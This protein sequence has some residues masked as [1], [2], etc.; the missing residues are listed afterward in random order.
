VV[1]N[2]S[3]SVT[4]SGAVLTVL[5]LPVI[6]TQPLSSATFAGGSVTLAGA[7]SGNPAPGYQWQK[8]GIDVVGATSGTLTLNNVQLSD[9]G[10]YALVATNSVGVATSR[11]ARLVVLVPRANAAVYNVKAY[12][13]GA[14]VGGN[15]SVEYG[16]TNVGTQN[17]GANHFLAVRDSQGLFVAFAPLLGTAAGEDRI[18]NVNFPAPA[19][20]GTYTYTVQGYESGVEFF[21]TQTTLTLTVLAPAGNAITY[22]T[23]NFP[24]TVTPGSNLIFNYNVTNTG[25][26]NWGT[27]HFLS[28]RDGAGVYAQFSSLNGVTPGQSKTVNM[29]FTAPSA[30]GV[31]QYYVQALENG[32]EF[33]PAQANLTLTV[34]APQPNAIVYTKTRSQDNVT[35]GATVNLR[36]SLS[37]AGTGTWGSGHYASLRDSNG[38]YLAFVP[39]NGVAPGAGTTVNFS[40]VAPTTPGSYSYFVQALEDGVEFFDK[41]ELVTLNVLALPIANAGS[42]D[43]TNFPTTAA[44]GA[45]VAFTHNVTNRGTKTW[46]TNH[47]LALRDAD[48]TF[49]GFPSLSG[50]APGQSKTVNYSFTAPTSPGVYTYHVQGLEGGIEFFNEAD[51]LVLIVP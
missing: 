14:T 35:P 4:S 42:Y 3:G 8:N 31:Y 40:F 36:Y 9:A 29:S 44:R 39:L 20:P 6:T 11:F 50:I 46:G 1:S 45:T 5:P 24:I 15:V 22:N 19:T 21:N 33:F 16:L 25:T 27:N 30:P 49:L 32:V 13:T 43:T 48:S 26:K 37:N 17:W 41:Q 47:F 10:S 18:V 23:T 51:D 38:T 28:L 2:S 12:P 34:L 7:A